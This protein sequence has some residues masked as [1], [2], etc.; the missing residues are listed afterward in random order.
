MD[1]EGSFAKGAI[2]TSR[3]RYPYSIVWTPLPIDLLR[4][5]FPFI[6]HM[7]ICTSAGVIR[8]FAGPYY[9]SED[10]MGFDNPT[11]YWQL[12]P[13]NRVAATW[14]SAVH[15][16][17]EEYSH[18]MLSSKQGIHFLLISEGQTRLGAHPTLTFNSLYPNNKAPAAHTTRGHTLILLK[19]HYLS[20]C[21]M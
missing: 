16:A 18:R 1:V 9:V 12:N 6:G 14:D 11:M 2:Y 4:W 19:L 8:D 3:N 15:Q 21:G 17:F 10:Q 20:S 13:K 7:G 5:F